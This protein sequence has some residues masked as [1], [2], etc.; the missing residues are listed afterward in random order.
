MKTACTEK[1]QNTCKQ[2]YSRDQRTTK[3]PFCGNQYN[4]LALQMERYVCTSHNIRI[5]GKI[6]TTKQYTD[7]NTSQNINT[8]DNNGNRE[9]TRQNVQTPN[10]L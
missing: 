8:E 9:M 2:K 10:V 1:M 4:I 7:N 6:K 5:N 3:L